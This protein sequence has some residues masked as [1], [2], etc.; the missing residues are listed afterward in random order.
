MGLK[1]LLVHLEVGRANTAVLQAAAMLAGRFDAGVIGVAACQ[2]MQL[3][4]SDTYVDANLINQDR[5]ETERE[6]A[7]AKV[8]FHAA[9]PSRANRLTWCSRMTLLPI[10]EFVVA[11]AR[12]ADLIIVGA[13]PMGLWHSHMRHASN[14]DLV[15]QAGRPV[16]LVPETSRPIGLGEVLVGWK[17]GREARRAVLDAL[18]LLQ[19]AQHVNV[20]EVAEDA[21]AGQAASRVG[22]VAAWLRLHD[23]KADHQVETARGQDPG[24]LGELAVQYG[25]D[26][27]VAGAYGH[28]R[29][30]EWALGGVTQALLTQ[31]GRFALL[32]H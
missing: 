25:A 29:L 31:P 20:V 4:Y 2:P 19:Q 26:M 14:S 7:E 17:D 9:F 28:S 24:R 10:H 12:N 6:L 1:T 3:V 27:I 8:E 23:I 13:Q 11:N 18:P 5:A 32:S 30:R 22:N 16:L 21:D 15:M